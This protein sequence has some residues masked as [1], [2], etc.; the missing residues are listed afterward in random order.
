MENA[1]GEPSNNNNND[2]RLAIME[3]ANMISVPMS[4]NAVV[5]LKVTDAVWEN[6]SNA[7]LSPVEILAKIRGPQGGGD[8]ENLQR[9]LRM[10]TSY[11]VFKE[12]VDDGSQRRYFL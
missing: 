6:G 12:H 7:P 10:L 11:G 4:L 1:N 5:K 8:A 2:E 9:I 3:L